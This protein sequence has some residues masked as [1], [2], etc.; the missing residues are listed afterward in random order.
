MA[1]PGDWPSKTVIQKRPSA[2]KKGAEEKKKRKHARNSR[3]ALPNWRMTTRH[4][5]QLH[6]PMTWTLWR[7]T[8]LSLVAFP[9]WM[10]RRRKNWSMRFFLSVPGYQGAYATNPAPSVVMAQFDSPAMALRAIRNQ[11]FNPKM[12]EHKLWA[13]ENRSP[14]ERR[15]LQTCEQ[16]E[17]DVDLNMT[18]TRR[19]MWLSTTS[20]FMSASGTA[21]GYRSVG[22][23]DY[24]RKDGMDG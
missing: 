14:N 16:I 1:L 22:Y 23:G 8:V 13:S 18:N 2:R 3:T 19:K 4:T 21:W 5:E 24:R 17:G 6:R 10:A 9:T 20:G 11:K 7:R 15:Q 12:Q